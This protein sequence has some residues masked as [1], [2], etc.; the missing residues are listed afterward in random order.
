VRAQQKGP[1]AV[2][3]S[4]GLGNPYVLLLSRRTGHSRQHAMRVMMVM[5]VVLDRKAHC[6]QANGLVAACQR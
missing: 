4:A 6:I 5:P 3:A 1:L 2:C